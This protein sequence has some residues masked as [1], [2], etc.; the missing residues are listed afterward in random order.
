VPA[1]RPQRDLLGTRPVSI[2]SQ[3]PG[4]PLPLPAAASWL[5]GWPGYCQPR[6]AA[7]RAAYRGPGR[8]RG[9]G[10]RPGPA[11][12]AR[13]G[14]G[15]RRTPSSSWRDGTQGAENRWAD[16][17]A[18]KVVDQT[19]KARAPTLHKSTGLQRIGMP[20]EG[21]RG[22]YRHL[23]RPVCRKKQPRAPVPC[24]QRGIERRAA[25]LQFS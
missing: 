24:L 21:H 5:V 3:D 6:A 19:K 17:S 16:G 22:V 11:G 10:G 25:K 8:E 20:S 15:I 13:R 4:H 12:G 7:T 2:V 23:A 14:A 1:L 18:R 9:E